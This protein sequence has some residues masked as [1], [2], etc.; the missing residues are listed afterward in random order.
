M[1]LI[2]AF[3]I[4]SPSGGALGYGFVGQLVS[5]EWMWLALAGA[6]LSSYRLVLHVATARRTRRFGNVETRAVAVF[7]FRHNEFVGI[8]KHCVFSMLD[9]CQRLRKL[10]GCGCKDSI[11][12]SIIRLRQLASAQF[13]VCGIVNQKVRTIGMLRTIWQRDREAMRF[14]RIRLSE[15]FQQSRVV[16]FPRRPEILSDVWTNAAASERRAVALALR[17]M[18]FPFVPSRP[19]FHGNTHA[20]PSFNGYV[21]ACMCSYSPRRR[22]AL[23]PCYLSFRELR[24][25]MAWLVAVLVNRRQSFRVDGRN[26]FVASARAQ[27]SSGCSALLRRAAFGSF[28]RCQRLVANAIPWHLSRLLAATVMSLRETALRAVRCALRYDGAA[29]AFA[30]FGWNGCAA[31]TIPLAL[32]GCLAWLGF[33]LVCHNNPIV[34]YLLSIAAFCA[35]ITPANKTTGTVV[36]AAHW[37]QDV[38]SNPILLKTP[39]TDG[40]ALRLVELVTTTATTTY[41]HDIATDV[42]VVTAGDVTI[43]LA[44]TTSSSTGRM[45]DIKVLSTGTIRYYGG[46]DLSIDKST[47]TGRTLN[48]LDSVRLVRYRTTDWGL[49]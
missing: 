40:G 32:V 43:K 22:K 45:L 23:V 10:L 41:E 47:S 13:D 19:A 42:I 39:I 18:W 46:G 30:R 1:M 15:V 11:A 16:G 25:R 8:L 21:F 5:S 24:W 2:A 29:S 6:I 14:I 17:H 12:E 7:P 48:F 4:G 35:W 37:N 36:T 38:V 26:Q 31:A 9:N 28:G 34:A 33:V 3:I 20:H 44:S 27:H 49:M